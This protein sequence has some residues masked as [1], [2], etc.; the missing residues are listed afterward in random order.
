M[1]IKPEQLFGSLDAYCLVCLAPRFA[2][3]EENGVSFASQKC[4]SARF[5]FRFPLS[6]SQFRGCIINSDFNKSVRNK[7][8]KF[9]S[10]AFIAASG[11]ELNE[12]AR[13]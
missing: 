2:S 9:P 11:G 1:A 7:W 3:E 5:R 8:G 12:R 4:L 6:R 13:A 10:D